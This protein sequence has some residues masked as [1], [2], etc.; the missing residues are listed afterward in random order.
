ME[1]SDT[2]TSILSSSL[3]SGQ[4]L[5][6]SS[7]SLDSCGHSKPSPTRKEHRLHEEEGDTL[8]D[9]VSLSSRCDRT[10]ENSSKNET[11]EN[12][13][14]LNSSEIVSPED[15]LHVHPGSDMS[16]TST[17]REKKTAPSSP[18][19][20]GSSS[21]CSLPLEPR[22]SEEKDCKDNSDKTRTNMASATVESSS[23]S[24]TSR[25]SSSCLVSSTAPLSP[26]EDDEEAEE[27]GESVSCQL[28]KS[29]ET[30]VAMLPSPKE[31]QSPPD[32]LSSLSPSSLSSSSSSLPSLTHNVSAVETPVTLL[33]KNDT[34]LRSCSSQ[35]NSGLVSTSF[36]S[37]PLSLALSSIS[38]KD[39]TSSSLLQEE[40]EREGVST[41]SH[42][43][44]PLSSPAPV[45]QA[46]SL[47]CESTSLHSSSLLMREEPLLHSPSHLLTKARDDVT[48]A[49]SLADQDA[50]KGGGKNA[51]GEKG[52]SKA[53]DLSLLETASKDSI[54]QD[55]HSS[56]NRTSSPPSSS[57]GD[58]NPPHETA[59][60]HSETS[61]LQPVSSSFSSEVEER[62]NVPQQEGEEEK[63]EREDVQ[64]NTK[65]TK[66]KEEEKKIQGQSNSLSSSSSSFS[67]PEML[68]LP[69]DPLFISPTSILSSSSLSS[70]CSHEKDLHTT[71]TV[72]TAIITTGTHEVL[73]DFQEEEEDQQRDEE[74]K[75]KRGVA[76]PGREQEE[77]DEKEGKEGELGQE[78]DAKKQEEEERKEEEKE[79]E[80]GEEGE[81]EQK[82]LVE[83]TGS[84]RQH[85]HGRRVDAKLR[86]KFKREFSRTWVDIN[87]APSWPPIKKNKYLSSDWKRIDL[88]SG[89]GEIRV[90][91]KKNRIF[92]NDLCYLFDGV[93]TQKSTLGRRAGLGLFCE[94]A[95]GLHKGQIITEFVGWLV[96]RDLAE[97]YRKQRTASHIV[98]VQKG[99]LY[100][101]GAKDPAYGMGG[102]S[103]ANDGSE[104]LGGPGNNSQFYHW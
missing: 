64:E 29:E 15:A 63:K 65:E 22:S 61:G 31:L 73:S 71:S 80:N 91:T 81:E 93:F 88:S 59:G 5:P 46:P 98:A 74:K 85:L 7:L 70:S 67:P 94:R 28:G 9:N 1:R 79:Q 90:E 27:E 37:S 82:N 4:S 77:N 55:I 50:S 38:H 25:L 99:F 89:G 2:Y 69:Q 95:E 10:T 54:D 11:K 87:R 33:S 24:S 39:Q 16:S 17:E 86:L 49:G 36:S 26:K 83:S 53:S 35:K 52:K 57:A 30:S 103:F 84:H 14:P 3:P 97:N 34:S 72:T 32:F 58:A 102:G 51:P 6:P 45:D 66:E 75:E 23:S 56:L 100:I 42:E 18:L 60:E 21:L 43:H 19:V 62:K 68:N 76:S 96:D 8:P 12:S 44:V 78:D 92:L 40:K 20:D 47:H 13:F 101:D 104:F 41:A 48:S